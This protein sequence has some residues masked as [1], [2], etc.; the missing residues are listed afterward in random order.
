MKSKAIKYEEAVA[1]NISTFAAS[2]A[3]S[4]GADLK[5]LAA[6]TLESAKQKVGIRKTDSK[7]DAAISASLAQASGRLEKSIKNEKPAAS[8]T[9]SKIDNTAKGSEQ[10]EIDKQ[11][12]AQALKGPRTGY[13]GV[14]LK[15][16]RTKV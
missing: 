16:R 4:E 15:A 11:L 14:N 6:Y 12:A 8:K 2:T 9:K 5:R 10:E 13:L 3:Q 7:H 1:R